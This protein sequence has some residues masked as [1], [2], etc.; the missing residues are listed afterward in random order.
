MLSLV[1]RVGKRLALDAL[2][3]ASALARYYSDRHMTAW[4]KTCNGTSKE[5]VLLV[6]PSVRFFLDLPTSPPC[7]FTAQGRRYLPTPT[8]LAI[9]VTLLV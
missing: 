9:D 7:K 4:Q 6:L 3:L 1:R 8:I 5:L 2:T